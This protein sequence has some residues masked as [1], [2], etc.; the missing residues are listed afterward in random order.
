MRKRDG[1][2]RTEGQEDICGRTANFGVS[3]GLIA[4]TLTALY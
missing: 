3:D 2:C 4:C 1:S